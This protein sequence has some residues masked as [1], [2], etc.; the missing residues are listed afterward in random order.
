MLLTLIIIVVAV[1]LFFDYTNGF[2]DAAN[3]IA[4]SI[5]TRA[6]TPRVALLMAAVFNVIGALLGHG[7]AQTLGSGIITAP[8]G[9]DGLLVV[10]PSH[11]TPAIGGSPITPSNAVLDDPSRRPP[12]NEASMPRTSPPNCR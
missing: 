6:L 8:S 4:T 9:S 2:H 1:A 10:S 5:S 12:E 11:V 7:V 3:S